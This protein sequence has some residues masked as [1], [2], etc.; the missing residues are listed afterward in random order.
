PASGGAVIV[1]AS[2]ADVDQTIASV[3]ALT[4]LSAL[5]AALVRAVAI[6][7]LMRGAL[8]PLVRLA[9][10]ADEIERTGD[11]S[12]RPP[13]PGRRDEVGAPAATSRR[14]GGPLRTSSGTR[15]ATDRRAGAS[16]SRFRP[17]VGS[18][19]RTRARGLR[20]PSVRSSGSGAAAPTA[21][22]RG[23][24][25]RSCARRRNGTA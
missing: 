3:R 11:P 17:R 13:E 23:S 6:M 1:G 10:A 15:A 2:R 19:S 12:R 20:R 22:A 8:R 5:G 16:G 18:A 9:R 14:S 21:P 25:W 24:G 7:L 4:L